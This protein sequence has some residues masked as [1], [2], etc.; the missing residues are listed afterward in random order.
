MLSATAA[1]TPNPGG[2]SPAGSLEPGK[3][4][5][6][7]PAG[8]VVR[9]LA[10]QRRAGAEATRTR[11]TSMTARGDLKNIIRD[12]MVKT[13]ESYTAAR[14]QVLRARGPAAT[15]SRGALPDVP[16]P[17]ATVEAVV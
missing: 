1:P 12:R 6:S 10:A 5:C 3:G 14:A 7:P 13:G 17:T 8:L 2:S 16:A 15:P 11:R 4:E 9:L